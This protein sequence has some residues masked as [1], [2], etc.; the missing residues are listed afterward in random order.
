MLKDIFGNNILTLPI[1][2]TSSQ[3]K[4]RKHIRFAAA[5]DFAGFFAGMSNFWLHYMYLD[6]QIC[7]V[8][9]CVLYASK[10]LMPIHVLTDCQPDQESRHILW[11]PIDYTI[12]KVVIISL[13]T[14]FHHFAKI[15]GWKIIRQ[16]VHPIYSYSKYASLDKIF[17]ICFGR[18]Q[19]DWHKL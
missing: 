9:V 6:T 5:T 3:A 15:H 7:I 19:N 17:I 11:P 16:H 10:N 2:P 13:N 18:L 4:I 14:S 1:F 12:D 8:P